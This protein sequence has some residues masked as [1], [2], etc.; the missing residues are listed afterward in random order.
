MPRRA[1]EN[2]QQRGIRTPHSDPASRRPDEWQH[3]VGELH[4]RG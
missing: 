3:I 4:K 1:A 2:L